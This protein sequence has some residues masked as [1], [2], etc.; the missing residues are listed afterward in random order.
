[1]QQKGINA[2]EIYDFYEKKKKTKSAKLE[3]LLP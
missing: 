3:D 1:M 2:C